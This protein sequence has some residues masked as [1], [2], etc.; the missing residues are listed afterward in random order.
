ML[1]KF[2]IGL[3]IFAAVIIGLTFFLT[4]GM[5][6]V[7]DSMF[8]TL[9]EK[10]YK[11]AY[12]S[13]FSS[14]FKNKITLEQFKEFVKSNS[15]DRVNSTFWNSREY[16]GNG[17]KLDGTVTLNDGSSMPLTLS[18]Y[19]NQ[20][21][22]KIYSIYKPNAGIKS[23]SSSKADLSEDDYMKLSLS[24]VGY[25][26]EAIKNKD[27]TPFYNSISNIWKKQTS[28]EELKK[29]FANILKSS[30]VVLDILQRE[31]KLKEK[32]IDDKSLLH[33]TLE[34]PATA[35]SVGAEVKLDYLKE[36]GE[37][38]LYGFEIEPK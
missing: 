27:F 26:K 18:F 36:D 7:A 16:K 32:K 4:S 24:S 17:G 38:K 22:W 34:Y 15:L 30:D 6:D 31:P 35:K 12:D 28:I 21:S 19:K 1:K 2:F 3:F 5:S 14:D 8:N 29:A 13:Y 11:E 20:D 25:F 9:K 23:K 10:K 33:I 37:W